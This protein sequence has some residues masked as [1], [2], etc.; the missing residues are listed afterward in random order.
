MIGARDRFGRRASI[1]AAALTLAALAACEVTAPTDSSDGLPQGSAPAGGQAGSGSGGGQGASVA[2]DTVYRAT[3]S[4]LTASTRSVIETEEDWEDAWARITSVMAPAPE[5]PAV[6]FGAV[7]VVVLGLGQRSSG[8]YAIEL[9]GVVRGDDGLTVT[10][11]ELAP[12]PG[13]TTTQALSQP[14]LAF[15]LATGGEAVRFQEERATRDCS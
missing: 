5:V 10:V 6:D 4:G 14:V 1:A 15:T 7:R 11:R 12:G 2:I 3:V 13:C 8:G 9:G